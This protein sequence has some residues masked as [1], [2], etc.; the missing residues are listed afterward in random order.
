MMN[1]S[2]NAKQQLRIKF[3]DYFISAEYD[4][5]MNAKSARLLAQAL[6]TKSGRDSV[7]H[8]ICRFS[9]TFQTV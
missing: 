7:P 1:S 5:P 9:R 3:I 6:G 2:L 4:A 8:F